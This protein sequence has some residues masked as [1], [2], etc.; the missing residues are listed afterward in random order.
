M[1]KRADHSPDDFSKA[2]PPGPHAL[3]AERIEQANLE[4]NLGDEADLNSDQLSIGKQG[5]ALAQGKLRAFGASLPRQ[6][7]QNALL[8]QLNFASG[9]WA[10]AL[11]RGQL[12][13]LRR[14][15]NN[16]A[17]YAGTDRT[18]GGPLPEAEEALQ[19]AVPYTFEDIVSEIGR[20]GHLR[21][22]I[23]GGALPHELSI[24]LD[25]AQGRALLG[26]IDGHVPVDLALSK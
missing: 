14:V 23:G 7:L 19:L 8:L 12:N 9:G 4:A 21:L 25:A 10:L 13:F 11:S 24:E 20:D 17:D 26:Y 6:P 5:E 18:E 22:T 1:T 16:Y 15:L 2:L 3:E